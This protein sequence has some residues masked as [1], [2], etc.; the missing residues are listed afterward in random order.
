MSIIIFSSYLY[1]RCGND[2]IFVAFGKN[3]PVTNLEESNLIIHTT[4]LLRGKS[5]KFS[6]ALFNICG[7]IIILQGGEVFDAFKFHSL[8]I[9][10]E[11]GQIPES[12]Q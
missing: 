12:C 6:A 3:G 5:L 1:D 8:T 7:F 4:Y 2:A 11:G 10:E 9:L